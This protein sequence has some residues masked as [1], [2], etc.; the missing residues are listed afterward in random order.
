MQLIGLISVRLSDALGSAHILSWN[1]NEL[2]TARDG[3]H[4]GPVGR[5]SSTSTLEE[6]QRRAKRQEPTTLS[7]NNPAGDVW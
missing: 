4:T 7:I 2:I 3:R 6:Y 5:R 1:S